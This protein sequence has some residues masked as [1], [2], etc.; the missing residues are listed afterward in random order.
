ME[1]G[2]RSR[3]ARIGR[4]RIFSPFARGGMASIHLGRLVGPAGFS[5][6]VALKVLDPLYADDEHYTMLLD[7]AR[8]SAAVRHPNVVQTLDVVHDERDLCI[9]MEYVHGLD[10]ATAISAA[11][12]LDE[13]VPTPIAS[14][15]LVGVLHG[16]HAAHEAR[17]EDGR[18]LGLVHRDISP[19]NVVVGVDGMARVLDFGIAKALRKNHVTAEGHVKGRIAYI[20]P[21]Q[22]VGADVTR[23][24]DVYSAGV[25]LWEALTG[26]HLFDEPNQEA[27]TSRVL[28]G[29]IAPPSTLAH[30]VGAALDA[31]VLR[32]LATERRDRFATAQEMAVALMAAVPPAT[33]D[34][35]AAWL[36]RIAGDAIEAR[37]EQLREAEGSHGEPASEATPRRAWRPFVLA[38]A[39]LLAMGAGLSIAIAMRHSADEARPTADVPSATATASP[40]TSSSVPIDDVPPPSP[41]P[42]VTGGVEPVEVAPS[43]QPASRPVTP[44][45]RATRG[46]DCNPPFAIDAKGIKHYKMACLK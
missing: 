23:Q 17:G 38:A 30:G 11:R 10:L 25:V 39:A 28:E 44:A 2:P 24:A 32:A 20:P 40:T 36:E 5:R 34:E 9:V 33:N 29:Q 46:L 16:L 31:I 15:I 27:L 45:A 13:P 37:S 41:A 1:S 19:Q 3:P 26:R 8:L 12:Q 21:E 4:Y 35:V 14:A 7:E 22:L 18:P 6:L 43:A 42:S